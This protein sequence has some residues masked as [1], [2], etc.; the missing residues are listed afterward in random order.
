MQGLKSNK[1]LC[2]IAKRPNTARGHFRTFS[3][4]SPA[5][6]QMFTSFKVVTVATFNGGDAFNVIPD[7]V[8]I[9][10]T[11]RAFSNDSFYRLKQRI[12]EIIVGQAVVY[13]CIAAVEFLEEEHPFYLPTV[14]D[15]NLY[16]YFQRIA[17]DLVGIHNL[18]VMPPVM[19][20]EDFSFYTEIVPGAFFF[21]GM[22]NETI[23][24][25]HL[26]HSPFFTIDENVLP[27]G[28]AMY[29]AIA[30]RYLNEDKPRTAQSS[31]SVFPE[32]L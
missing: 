28:A 12:E 16:D 3:H 26:G 9:G 24:S 25:T 27:L 11:F 14:N 18:E 31:G 22:R 15:K 7:S 5:M 2:E 32:V 4:S 19:G 8:T 6:W 17:A 23:G 29:A 21:I 20:A 10:G 13:R 1:R 30:E